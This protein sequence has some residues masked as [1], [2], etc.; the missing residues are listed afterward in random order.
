MNQDWSCLKPYPPPPPPNVKIYSEIFQIGLHNQSPEMHSICTCETAL[1]TGEVDD[2][3]IDRTFACLESVNDWD[4]WIPV[5]GMALKH[6]SC[7]CYA[8]MQVIM[9]LFHIV[10][11]IL[12]DDIRI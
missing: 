10:W 9:A 6:H 12:L 11:I 3:N 1:P 4:N 8:R 5:T 7:V 2:A